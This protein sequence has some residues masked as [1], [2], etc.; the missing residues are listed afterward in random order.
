MTDD[1]TPTHG[2]AAGAEGT[3]SLA[4][5]LRSA[6]SELTPAEKK[7]ARAILA[8]YPFSGLD[9]ISDLAETAGVSAPSVVRFARTLGFNGYREFQE[10]LKHEIRER[11]ESNLSQAEGRVSGQGAVFND[12]RRAY[13]AGIDQ[14]FDAVIG[15]ELDRTV[16]LLTQTKRAVGLIG[17]TYSGY[18]ADIFQAQLAPVRPGVTRVASNPVVAAG[19]LLDFRRGDLLIAFDVRRYE[20]TIADVVRVGKELGLTT[21]V[22]TDPWMSPAAAQADHVLT[23]DVRA[24]GPSDT[25]VPMLA[26]VEAVS[27]L[28]VAELGESGIDRLARLDPLRLS[29]GGSANRA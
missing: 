11:E 17:A 2:A 14:T 3:P 26:L 15:D 13:H 10:A 7:I 29:L 4:M 21:I 22:F 23:A 24:A 27:E 20:P 16:S 28:V 25:L 12:A 9:S 19:Q 1:S 6:M 5:R 18:I 8:S